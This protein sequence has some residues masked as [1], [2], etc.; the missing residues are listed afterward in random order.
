MKLSVPVTALCQ[1]SKNEIS[2][3]EVQEVYNPPKIIKIRVLLKTSLLIHRV[4][5]EL[6]RH[7]PPIL[8]V[9]TALGVLGPHPSLSLCAL[10]TE[11]WTYTLGPY[12][13]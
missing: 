9:S 11:R 5:G 10:G 7:P 6:L 8:E 12:M 2:T 4:G 13:D 1:N 3:K